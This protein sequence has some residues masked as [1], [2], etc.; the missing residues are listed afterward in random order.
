MSRRTKLIIT[1]L[2]LVLLGIPTIYVVLTWHAVNPLRFRLVSPPPKPGDDRPRTMEFEVENTS[3]A[4]IHVLIALWDESPEPGKLGALRGSL[5][6]RL[7]P[8]PDG[9]VRLTVPARST[10]RFVSEIEYMSDTEGLHVESAQIQYGWFSHPKYLTSRALD[11]IS[12]FLPESPQRHYYMY[13]P[14]EDIAP[15]ELATPS[16]PR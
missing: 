7:N 6:S 11:W 1:A 2:F 10:L 16:T 8:G 13:N 9:L 5:L 14:D 15:L 4:S 3:A 12:S